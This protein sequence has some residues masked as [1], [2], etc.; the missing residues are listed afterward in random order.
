MK[1]LANAAAD[2]LRRQGRN[3]YVVPVGASN[4]LGTWGY[5]DAVR[6]L[7]E[8]LQ[9]DEGGEGDTLV[10]ESADAS[11]AAGVADEA[12][13]VVVAQH[14]QQ[15]QQCSRSSRA[16]R[17]QNCSPAALQCLVRQRGPWR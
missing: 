12:V 4:A 5:I 13:A 1:I 11:E 15:E 3:P 8:Q 10:A 14:V 7:R 6:E 16:A 2:K 17:V 9:L